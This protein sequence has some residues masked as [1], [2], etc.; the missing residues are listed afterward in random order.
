[1]SNKGKHINYNPKSL[2]NLT[3]KYG[4]QKG[5]PA[6]LMCFKEIIGLVKLV[7]RMEVT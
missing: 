6:Y 3:S 7:E 1:M 5:K 2:L 4:F